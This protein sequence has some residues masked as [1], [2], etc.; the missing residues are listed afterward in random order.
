MIKNQLSEI[1]YD[2][3]IFENNNLKNNYL[4]NLYHHYKETNNIIDMSSL[5]NTLNLSLYTGE[6]TDYNHRLIEIAYKDDKVIGFCLHSKDYDCLYRIYL[7]VCSPSYRENNIGTSLFNRTLMNIS[8]FS[9]DS[10][11]LESSEKLDNYNFWIS[12]GAKRIKTRYVENLFS[13]MEIGILQISNIKE[14]VN[15]LEKQQEHKKLLI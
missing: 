10:C 13:V 2:T 8:N 1:E 7:M 4:F 9:F 6:D 5:I 15:N 11:V 12:K 3:F 14:Y